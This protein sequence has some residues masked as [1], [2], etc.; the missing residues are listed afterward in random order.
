MQLITK[1]NSKKALL[2]MPIV[3]D[4]ASRNWHGEFQN[5]PFTEILSSKYLLSDH[6]S[7]CLLPEASS[8]KPRDVHHRTTRRIGLGV[9]L[10]LDLVENENHRRRVLL[11]AH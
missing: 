11:G 4:S 8:V 9:S 7:V 3:V 6:E 2:K 10:S 5:T 1:S